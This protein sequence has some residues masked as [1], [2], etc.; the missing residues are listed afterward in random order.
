MP[1]QGRDGS[2]LRAQILGESYR[3]ATRVGVFSSLYL[4]PEM[5]PAHCYT[6]FRLVVYCTYLLLL[7]YVDNYE[8]KSS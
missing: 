7:T 4:L 1:S 5:L 8:V 6:G 3:T 2:G